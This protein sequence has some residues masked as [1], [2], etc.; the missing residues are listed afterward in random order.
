MNENGDENVRVISIHLR[1]CAFPPPSR[2]SLPTSVPPTI[3]DP[4]Q[5]IDS[6]RNAQYGTLHGM[7]THTLTPTHTSTSTP[8]L[9]RLNLPPEAGI[10]LLTM[11]L[12]SAD[13]RNGWMDM[14]G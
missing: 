7:H 13:G 6:S 2:P 1:L 3:N 12:L 8:R 10:S 11:L 5:S 4:F 14:A 9:I